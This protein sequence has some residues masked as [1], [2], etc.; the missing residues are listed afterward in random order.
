MF[1]DIARDR[2][3]PANPFEITF[4]QGLI[5]GL[6]GCVMT[7]GLSLVTER[8]HGTLVRLRAVRDG[9]T[10]VVT[11]EDRGPGIA[12]AVRECPVR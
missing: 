5:W 4:P 9:D 3:G 1:L 6:I 12:D 10:V 7:F 2:R 11:V 8:T